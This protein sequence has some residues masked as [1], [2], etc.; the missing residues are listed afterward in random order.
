MY[1]RKRLKCLLAIAG[2]LLT[3]GSLTVHGEGRTYT[4]IRDKLHV[5]SAQTENGLPDDIKEKI[6]IP[7]YDDNVPTDITYEGYYQ[8]D[9]NNRTYIDPNVE[10]RLQ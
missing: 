6:K 3:A 1:Y 9:G 8:V 7:K 10:L 2:I 5:S 4:P